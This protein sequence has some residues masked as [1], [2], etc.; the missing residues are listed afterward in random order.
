MG[1]QEFHRVDGPKLAGLEGPFRYITGIV[2]Y[3]D[4]KEGQYYNANSDMYITNEEMAYHLG[5]RKK[6]WNPL[7][8]N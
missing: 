5:H 2:L 7:A 4:P 6:D 8:T 1:Y 3:Y